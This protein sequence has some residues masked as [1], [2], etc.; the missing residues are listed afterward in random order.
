MSTLTDAD[1]IEAAHLKGETCSRCGAEIRW[2]QTRSRNAP[3]VDSLFSAVLAMPGLVAHRGCLKVTADVQIPAGRAGRAPLQQVG[4]WEKGPVVRK[5]ATVTECPKCGGAASRRGR[6]EAPTS[7]RQWR[8]RSV[9][10]GADGTWRV[11]ADGE[12][13]AR[14]RKPRAS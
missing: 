6:P 7:S 3:A 8:C 14:V 2:D 4:A 10:C 5:G 13:V 11:T 9:A 12:I 1:V